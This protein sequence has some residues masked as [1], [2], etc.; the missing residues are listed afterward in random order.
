[1]RERLEYCSVII[2]DFVEFMAVHFSFHFSS[3]LHVTDFI[4]SLD[5]RLTSFLNGSEVACLLTLSASSFPAVS[6]W[7]EIQVIGI[8]HPLFKKFHSHS[9]CMLVTTSFSFRRF[10][11]AANTLKRVTEDGA[12]FDLLIFGE[13]ERFGVCYCFHTEYAS[14]CGVYRV[15]FFHYEFTTTVPTLFSVI[16]LSLCIWT[17]NI[18]QPSNLTTT[19]HP[20]YWLDPYPRRNEMRQRG[21]ETAKW[22]EVKR[23][24]IKVS[25]FLRDTFLAS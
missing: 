13:F 16:K 18:N 2:C 7:K 3:N 11:I 1:M 24:E 25:L 8:V 17:D 22:N 10:C 15:K 23:N 6:W 19:R 20:V 9:S 21:R 14:S 12:I 4:I 5:G